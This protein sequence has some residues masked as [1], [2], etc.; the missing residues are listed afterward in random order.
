[1][2]EGGGVEV[3]KTRKNSFCQ[4]VDKLV[5]A[6]G[7]SG[8]GGLTLAACLQN[9]RCNGGVVGGGCPPCRSQ[10]FLKMENGWQ[11]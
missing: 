11:F 5:Y 4:Q 9:N 1:M 10:A 3:S 7:G 6:R 8:G 2:R